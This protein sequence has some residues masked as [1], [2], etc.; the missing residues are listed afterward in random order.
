MAFDLLTA[1][2]N[3]AKSLDDKDALASFKSQFVAN[4]VIY[5]DGNSLGKL[6]LATISLMQESIEKNWGDRLI[7]SWN[8]NWIDLPNRIAGKIAKL[9][10][11]REDEVLVSDSTSINLYK[12]AFA[13]LQYKSN[14]NEIL[15][16]SFN[17]P[18]DLYILNGLIKNHF[19]QHHLK[20]INSKDGI[21]IDIKDLE[22]G[23]NEN[24]AFICLSHVQYKSAY[25]YDMHRVNDL[26]SKK[27]ALVLWDLSHAVG[28]VPIKLNEWNADLAVGCTYK[29]LNG[30]PGA[31]AF[32][33][34]K[35]ELQEKLNN[36]IQAWFAHEKPFDFDGNFIP[37]NSIQKFATSTPAI[38]SLAPIEI[39]VDMIL[40]A[41]LENIRNKGL[42]QSNFL[43]EMIRDFLEVL[44]FSILSPIF[45]NQRGSHISIQHPEAW[46]IN[47][48]MINPIKNTTVII[49][50]FRPPNTIRLGI[51]PLYTSYSDLFHGIERIYTI[52]QEK[53]Y[54]HFSREAKGVV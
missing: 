28:A 51:A 47:Q 9:I 1:Y 39:G 5:L 3:K 30:G 32:L 33:Y 17:F 29:Y 25:Q 11:A 2:R 44:G 13:A 37:S 16:D 23:I 35:K 41:G 34:V 53:E 10:G 46:R 8:E 43:I 50:D 36:P 4:D 22:D 21:S 38:L 40:K 14:K 42:S 19:H 31:S 52:M 7:R 24:T 6:P 49:P 18:S 48:A 54:L 27:N 45:E 12:L 20:V 15:T 26:A